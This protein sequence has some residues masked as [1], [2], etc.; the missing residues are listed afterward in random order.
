[1]A[2]RFRT[3]TRTNPRATP[4]PWRLLAL[5]ITD[6]T[7]KIILIELL[8]D[9]GGSHKRGAAHLYCGD[10]VCWAECSVRG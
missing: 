5:D 6:P 7:S 10:S 4:R 1:M 2:L 9:R 3:A 8:P